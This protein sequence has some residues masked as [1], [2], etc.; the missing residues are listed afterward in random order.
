MPSRPVQASTTPA[1][2]IVPSPTRSPHRDELHL[3]GQPLTRDTLATRLRQA[4]HP[5]RNARLTPLL[6]AL[7]SEAATTS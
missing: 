4:G 2:W 7:R 5:V 3:D 6:Q 1:T